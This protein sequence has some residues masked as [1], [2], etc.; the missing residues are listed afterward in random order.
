MSL[1]NDK[2]NI[3]YEESSNIEKEELKTLYSDAGWTLYTNDIDRLKDAVTNSLL[4]ITARSNGELVGLIRCVG[5]GRTI[6]YIQDI[7]VLNNFKRCGIGTRLVDMVLKKYH[8]V[9]QIVLLADDGE[10][11]KA[12]YESL[13]FAEVGK[14][15]GV[16][17]IK[18][19]S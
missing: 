1:M 8:D 13:G 16:C 18:V 6:V 12:F 7:L 14:N 10:D 4:T 17:F 11:V 9:R 19:K 3:A 5:D 2:E 15:K